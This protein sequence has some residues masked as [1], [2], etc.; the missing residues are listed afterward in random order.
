MPLHR[1]TRVITSALIAI[2]A[3]ATASCG[4]AGTPSPAPS[5]VAAPSLESPPPIGAGAL[6][7]GLPLSDAQKRWVDSTLASLTLRQRVAQMVSIWVLGDFSNERDSS[8]AQLVSW[9]E[10]DGVG[11]M[12]MSVGSPIEVAVKLNALQR[13]ARIPLLVHSDLEPGLGRLEGGVFLPSMLYGGSATVFPTE[14][15][16][17]AADDDSL[18]Y[19]A[20]FA[21]GREARAVGIQVVFG[22]VGEHHEVVPRRHPVGRQ[23]TDSLRTHNRMTARQATARATHST[24]RPPLTCAPA[25]SSGRPSPG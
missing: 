14:M 25:A 22:P 20:A 6:A 10:N 17:G 21:I 3:A 2:A 8:Y 13:H 1:F 23:I 4:P 15:A 5:P 11:S 18:T 12:T 19:A 9:I 7:P 24:F 16:M